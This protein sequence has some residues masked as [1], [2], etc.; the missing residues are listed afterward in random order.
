M[1]ERVTDRQANKICLL[2]CLTDAVGNPIAGVAVLAALLF[3]LSL[4]PYVLLLGGIFVASA[5]TSLPGMHKS[6][7]GAPKQPPLVPAAQVRAYV[8]GNSAYMLPW[9]VANND[10]WALLASGTVCHMSVCA[11]SH[12]GFEWAS[13]LISSALAPAFACAQVPRI[14]DAAL[15]LSF[16]K[17]RLVRGR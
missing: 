2:P 15:N 6:L 13:C 11:F 16:W 14:D 17:C 5:A 9:E 4:S 1:P 8:L 7:P 10:A 3:T 12:S